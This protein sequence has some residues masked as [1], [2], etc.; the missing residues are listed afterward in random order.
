MEKCSCYRG[1]RGPKCEIDCG[2]NGNGY[3]SNK[4]N[5]CVCD[6][7]YSVVNGKCALDC[8]VKSDRAECLKC[9]SSCGYGTCIKGKCVCWAGNQS[10]AK[11]FE[12][13]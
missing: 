12:I 5:E 3:C 10:K 9:S 2:C 7:G 6:L 11:F 8:T 4:T 1:Y 13:L